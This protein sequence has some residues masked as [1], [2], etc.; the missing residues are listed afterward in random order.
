M[1]IM[2]EPLYGTWLALIAAWLHGH[3][4]ETLWKDKMSSCIS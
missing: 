4:N 3:R 1:T 2:K